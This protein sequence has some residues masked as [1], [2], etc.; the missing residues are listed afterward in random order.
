MHTLILYIE[1]SQSLPRKTALKCHTSPACRLKCG[2][3]GQCVALSL[4]SR[5]ALYVTV[6]H[7]PKDK[8][9]AF[10]VSNLNGAA[11]TGYQNKNSHSERR[12]F[13][14]QSNQLSKGIIE[15]HLEVMVKIESR[16]HFLFYSCGHFGS[17]F[18]KVF[19][20]PLSF[21]VTKVCI[22]KGAS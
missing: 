15:S 4:T 7:K 19:L 6:T 11:T 21:V 2:V 8:L 1:H 3:L 14:T 13:K 22:E 18:W 20:C 12:K 9:P 10:Y 16:I 17:V 5:Y